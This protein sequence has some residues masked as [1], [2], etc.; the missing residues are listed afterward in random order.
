MDSGN[1]AADLSS[2]I[3]I[4]IT[5][6]SVVDDGSWARRWRR[7]RFG[8]RIENCRA[9]IYEFAERSRGPADSPL[10]CSSAAHRRRWLHFV[11]WVEQRYRL[12]SHSWNVFQSRL[13]RLKM[14]LVA[15]G[16]SWKCRSFIRV[17]RCRHLSLSLSLPSLSLFIS[18]YVVIYRSRAYCL[19][20]GRSLDK[21]QIPVLV[22][23]LN[24]ILLKRK[25]HQHNTM[26]ENVRE[27][28][29][30]MADRQRAISHRSSFF[31]FSLFCL[32]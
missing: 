21:V 2:P 8:W 23:Y 18:L 14:K 32:Y 24:W 27:L 5:I 26:H 19:L 28:S 13:R 4:T 30:V 16:L 1:S 7:Q 3:T 10:A 31:S 15:E 29:S 22:A 20:N 11:E 17:H 6:L 12:E 9:R 25:S